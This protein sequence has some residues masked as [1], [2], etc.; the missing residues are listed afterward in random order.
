MHYKSILLSV[1]VLLKL[2]SVSNAWQIES[3]DNS[4]AAIHLSRAKAEWRQTVA[5]LNDAAIYFSVDIDWRIKGLPRVIDENASIDLNNGRMRYHYARRLPPLDGRPSYVSIGEQ[6]FDGRVLYYGQYRRGSENHI[7][8]TMLGDNLDGKFASQYFTKR[9][10]YLEA[11]GYRLPDRAPAWL[12]SGLKSIALDYLAKCEIDSM[13]IVEGDEGL[14]E[15]SLVIPE[16]TVERAKS[17]DLKWTEENMRSN[18]IPVEEITQRVD[19]IKQH[20]KDALTRSVKLYVDANKKYT[21]VRRIERTGAGELI[22]DIK[23]RDF[24]SFGSPSI[25]LPGKATIETYAS[26]VD[27]LRGFRDNPNRTDRIDLVSVDLSSER[28]TK[29]SIQYGS[30]TTRIDRSSLA[31]RSAKKGAIY[32]IEP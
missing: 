17:I 8:M 3:P 19:E 5:T 31:S 25:W 12:D 27:L 13:N 24:R 9:C 6:A 18:G 10:I 22:Y 28:D 32:F 11:A 15:I 14:I 29:Y 4:R 21:I 30:G 7:L 23:G 2:L 16:P 20:R 1:V 26:Y